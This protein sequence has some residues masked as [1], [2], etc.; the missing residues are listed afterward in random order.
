MCRV[1]LS[2]H[3][4]ADDVPEDDYMCRVSLSY[5]A[6]A[7][8]VP[9]DDNIAIICAE[10]ASHLMQLQMM[11][12]KMTICAESASHLMQLQRMFLK[13]T[14]SPLYV[15]SQPLISCNCR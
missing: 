15:Q 10:S 11:F 8:D 12:L 2:S 4:I 7:E 14:I 9:E 5:H 13:M 3:A 1:S 6:I